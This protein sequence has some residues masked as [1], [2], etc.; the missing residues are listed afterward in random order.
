MMNTS[1]LLGEVKTVIQEVEPTADVILFGSRARDQASA[2]SDW[3][4]LVLITGQAD[5]ARIDKIRHRLYEIEWAS[6]EVLSSIVWSR[7][8]WDSEPYRFMPLH[9]EVERDGVRL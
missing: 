4:F 1:T 2:D 6:G 7:E 3:D 5:D 9:Q 8:E